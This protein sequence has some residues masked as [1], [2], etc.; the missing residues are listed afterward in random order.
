LG[1]PE[2]YRR[3]W[4]FVRAIRGEDGKRYAA[5][6]LAYFQCATSYELPNGFSHLLVVGKVEDWEGFSL[7]AQLSAISGYVSSYRIANNYPK[8]QA[9]IERWE[10][11]APNFSTWRLLFP[12]MWRWTGWRRGRYLGSEAAPRL[13]RAIAKFGAG[14]LDKDLESLEFLRW[15]Y[16]LPASPEEI[17]LGKVDI[18]EFEDSLFEAALRRVDYGPTP[19][20]FWPEPLAATA[21][22]LTDGTKAI[23]EILAWFHLARFH[24]GYAWR[25]L[26]DWRYFDEVKQHPRFQ[27]FLREEDE[28]VAEIEGQIDS[29]YFPL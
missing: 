13:L 22:A 25:V 8:L 5:R 24:Y 12:P 20:G 11:Y 21:L 18:S 10:E 28:V 26:T 16:Q 7:E 19:L 2:P 1:S 14:N 23:E 6:S 29:G 9:K 3:A 27:T 4:E 17:I 15:L